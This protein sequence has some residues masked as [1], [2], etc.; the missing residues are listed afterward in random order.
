MLIVAVWWERSSE[1]S[2]RG[3]PPHLDDKSALWLV[4]CGT[5]Q[6]GVVSKAA[7]SGVRSSIQLGCV[8]GS[9]PASFSCFKRLVRI[10]RVVI[11]LVLRTS[12][13]PRTPRTPRKNPQGLCAKTAKEGVLLPVPLLLTPDNHFQLGAV[14]YAWRSLWASIRAKG[15]SAMAGVWLSCG[16]LLVWIL[17]DDI[18]AYF[19]GPMERLLDAVYSVPGGAVGVAAL[20]WLNGTASSLIRALNPLDGAGDALRLHPSKVRTPSHAWLVLGLCTPRSTIY[21]GGQG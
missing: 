1:R 7:V 8:C 14:R 15:R 21:V 13:T 11:F 16:A 4:E 3:A 5:L 18:A 12:R 10:F 20:R 6:M 9:P 2:W 17:G 19:P